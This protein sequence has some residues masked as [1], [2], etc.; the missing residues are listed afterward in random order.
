MLAF[1]AGWRGYAILAAVVAALTG[2]SVWT[3]LGW[4][5][6]ATVSAI[7][8]DNERA[9]AQAQAYARATEQSRAKAATA[10]LDNAQRETVAVRADAAAARAASDKL[11]AELAS[12]RRRTARDTAASGTGSGESG[13]DT[14]DLLIR[15]LSGVD[16]AGQAV[17]GY[18]DE[19]RIAG[20]ACE[21]SH[22][23]LK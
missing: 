21:R 7:Q 20:L 15:L 13:A 8:R 12:L 3:V 6:D 14:L 2:G 22:D 18:A 23:S 19:L 17:S 1:L 5:C 11:R 9:V 10:I 4:R 16:T